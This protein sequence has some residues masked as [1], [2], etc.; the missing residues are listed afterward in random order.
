MG[1]YDHLVFYE[2]RPNIP[3]KETDPSIMKKIAF[4]DS[5]VMKGAP[6]FDIMWF[7]KPREPN[8]PEHTHDFDEFIGFIGSDPYDASDLG[9]TV[10]FKIEDEWLVIKKS[11]L[12]YIPAGLKHSPFVIE[13][14]KRPI[15]HFSGGPSV[16]YFR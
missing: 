4:L 10:N 7:V 16:E 14:M 6:Y 3:G 11:A 1:K 2:P 9:A 8:P 13:D 15:L 5:S 12:I